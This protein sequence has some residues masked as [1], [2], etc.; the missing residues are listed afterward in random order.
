[1][2]ARRKFRQAKS[3]A[4]PWI[5]LVLIIGLGFVAYRGA[6]SAVSTY[7]SWIADLP[8]INSDSKESLRIAGVEAMKLYKEVRAADTTAQV[9]NKDKTAIQRESASSKKNYKKHGT[10]WKSKNHKSRGTS[11]YRSRRRR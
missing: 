3:H 7:Q 4:I 1:M 5:A 6:A 8:A 10:S 11:R 2:K 9:I